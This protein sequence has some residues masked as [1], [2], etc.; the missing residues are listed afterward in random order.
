MQLAADRR[1]Q[2]IDSLARRAHNSGLT[3]VVIALLETHKPLSFIASQT[4]LVFQP[5]LTVFLGDISVEDYVLLLAD[6]KNLER[7]ICRLE[8]LQDESSTSK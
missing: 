8:E 2:L 6:R 4:F 5:L 1:D 7:V 3:T